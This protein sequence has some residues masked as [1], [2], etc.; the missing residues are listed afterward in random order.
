MY[1]IFMTNISPIKITLS[2]NQ[3]VSW[4]AIEVYTN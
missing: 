1:G 3:E 4:L 2:L